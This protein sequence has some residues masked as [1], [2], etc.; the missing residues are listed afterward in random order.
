MS[1]LMGDVTF[2]YEPDLVEAWGLLRP[3]TMSAL[4]WSPGGFC[5]RYS[6]C[7]EKPSR[8]ASGEN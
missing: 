8:Y 2:H 4:Q 3:G 6:F 1:W 5:R 7:G